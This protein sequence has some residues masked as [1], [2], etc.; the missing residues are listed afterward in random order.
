MADRSGWGF[1]KGLSVAPLARVGTLKKKQK[2]DCQCIVSLTS[3]KTNLLIFPECPTASTPLLQMAGVQRHWSPSLMFTAI[4]P[5]LTRGLWAS[6]GGVREPRGTHAPTPVPSSLG[7]GCS[8]ILGP[9]G[10]WSS[11][12]ITTGASSAELET[13]RKST[14]TFHST[15]FSDVRWTISTWVELRSDFQ[16]IN[17]NWIMN[18]FPCQSWERISSVPEETPNVWLGRNDCFYFK[19]ITAGT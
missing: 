4:F 9:S 7:T 14:E 18:Q 10:C 19:H 11:Q 6:G 16:L 17:V 13:K 1:H 3:V 8:R 5:H 2:R 12:H 15:L